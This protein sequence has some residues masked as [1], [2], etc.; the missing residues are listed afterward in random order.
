M[1]PVKKKIH[2]IE[3]DRE[4]AT[5]IA[6]ELVERGYEDSIAYDGAAG[7]AAIF[8][9]MPDLIFCDV[10]MPTMSGFEVLEH[11]TNIAPRFGNM[12]FLF[13]AALTDRNNE[14]RGRR[15][16]ADDYVSKPIDF[17]VL[18]AII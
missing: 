16:G 1:T 14:L 13:L 12:P 10:S 2:C 11:L 3:D 17:D 4:T 6:E 5:L 15:L 9:A 8:T 7:F 18:D